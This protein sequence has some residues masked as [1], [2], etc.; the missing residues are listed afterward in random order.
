M[1]TIFTRNLASLSSTIPG[2]DITFAVT[3]SSDYLPSDVSYQY[4]WQV[5]STNVTG[6]VFNSYTIDPLMTDN[7]KK[8]LCTVVALSNS[9]IQDTVN[10][11]EVT[12]EVRE[13][14]AP[15][16]R[17]DFGKETGRERHR[18]MRHLGYC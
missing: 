8:Y 6:A 2:R 18:R 14:V 3:A 13:D 17:F 7:G 1:A 4:Q 11:V 15:F 10:S 12:L 5:N 9:V 16:D